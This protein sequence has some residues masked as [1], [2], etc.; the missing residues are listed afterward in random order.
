MIVCLGRESFEIVEFLLTIDYIMII[1]FHAYIVRKIT[2]FTV[3][4]LKVCESPL[5]ICCSL[6][7]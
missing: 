3:T 7:K 1:T 5:F 2:L 6:Q 4:L